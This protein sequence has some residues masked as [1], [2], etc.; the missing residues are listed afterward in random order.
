MFKEK[1]QNV[2]EGYTFDDVLLKPLHSTIEPKNANVAS[3]FSRHINIGIPIVSSPMDTVTEDPMAIAMARYGAL[4]VIHRN[5]SANEQVEMIKKVKK[6]ESIII[7]DVFSI[8]PDTPVNVARTLMTTKNIAGLPVVASGKLIGILT[9][10]DLEFSESEG[11]VKDIMTK[12]VITADENVSIED[13]KYILYKNRV[14]KLPLV[15]KKGRLMGLITAKD[16]KTREKFPNASRDEQGQ[17]MVGAAIGAYDIDRAINLENAGSDFLVIDTAHAHNRN[18]LSSL[19][20]IRKAI[21][22]DIIAG[23]IA[24]AEAAEDLISMGVDGLRVGIGPGS[25]C[26]TRIVAGVGVPQLTAISDVADV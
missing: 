20:K 8:D 2:I 25:I 10:R 19:K 7:R 15:D 24:T 3:R 12:D 17:L 23:N 21:H 22:I 1:F 9:K 4:G 6:E 26:T 14:E 11:T 18:V 13:A 16:I 5:M